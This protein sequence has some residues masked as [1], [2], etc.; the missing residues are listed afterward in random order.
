MYHELIPGIK[1]IKLNENSKAGS[2]DRKFKMSKGWALSHSNIRRE[3]EV[4]A[5]EVEKE[6]QKGRGSMR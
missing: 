3:K 5:I 6:H 1:V 4:P 2:L